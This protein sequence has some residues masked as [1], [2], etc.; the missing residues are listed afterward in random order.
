M[1][2]LVLGVALMMCVAG[3]T[4]AASMRWYLNVGGGD[5]VA[6]PGGADPSNWA[7]AM[8]V[9]GGNGM[10][11]SIGMG[12]TS[13][14][15]DTVFETTACWAGAGIVYWDTVLQTVEGVDTPTAGSDIF[16]VVFNN[17]SAAAATHY[18]VVDD[19]FHRIPTYTQDAQLYSAGSAT[20]GEWQAVPEPSSL[21]LMGL[22]V[23]ALAVRRFR[24]K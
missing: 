2:K 24:K 12:G 10:I 22:G 17:A 15:D 11:D 19:A 23:A 8:F 5:S 7:V 1:K 21:A 3:V 13:S 20:E 9:D 14:G 18:V 6:T 16:T 4:H